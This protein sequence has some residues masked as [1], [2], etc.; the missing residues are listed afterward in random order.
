MRTLFF[1]ALFWGTMPAFFLDPFYGIVH[2]SL[3]NIIRPEQLL[4]GGG[5][6]RIFM[7][8]Q[9]VNFLA[10]ISTKDRPKIPPAFSPPTITQIK[11]ML[12]IATAMS[13][14]TTF[15][16]GPQDYSSRW[17]SQ[18]WK[19]VL[20]CF[21]MSKAINTSKKLQTYYTVSIVWFMVLQMWGIQQKLGG[22]ARMEGLG[23]DVLPNVNSLAAVAVLYF[24]MAYF[25]LYS[26]SRLVQLFAGVP[27]TVVSIIFILFGGS[28][29]AFLG[30]SGCFLYIFLITPGTQKFKMLFSLSV[31]G[32][33]LGLLLSV[34]AP[35]GFFDEYTARLETILGSEDEK[36]GEVEYE[37]SA[38]GRVAIW[39]TVYYVIK[40]NPEYWLL[41]VG[42]KCFRFV[43]PEHE[44]ELSVVLS[45]EEMAHLAHSTFGGELGGK[46]THNTFLDM[47]ASGGL[48]TFVPWMSLILFSWFQA[49]RIPKQ[50][51]KIVN[52]VNIHNYAKAIQVG[53][54]GGF[55]AGMFTEVQFTDFYYWHLTMSGIIKNIGDAHVR[56]QESMSEDDEFIDV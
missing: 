48:L 19:I 30:L 10:W 47:L 5:V 36:S 8:S 9:A 21:L 13:L 53:L 33:I 44:A 42:M 17:S 37:D 41:G 45:P 34:L 31:V 24:P 11:L 15:A 20:F 43:Y 23:G 52:G 14:S 55:L 28:R 56:Y 46:A 3:I 50:Y 12:F 2:Y 4:W 26:K 16:R 35:E 49:S 1:M 25:S 40:N 6:G 54:V 38:A 7:A 32:V 29:G 27:C 51:P 18:F 39:K 22:N